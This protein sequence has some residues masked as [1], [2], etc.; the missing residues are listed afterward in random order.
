M[1]LNLSNLDCEG[2]PSSL[3]ETVRDYLL[4]YSLTQLAVRSDRLKAKPV[5]HPIKAEFLALRQQVRAFEESRVLMKFQILDDQDPDLQK[6]LEFEGFFLHGPRLCLRGQKD[7]AL[8][9]FIIV[10]LFSL[11]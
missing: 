9:P 11:N 6:V 8:M 5:S 3:D 10:F 7:Q 4:A 1:K 2:L